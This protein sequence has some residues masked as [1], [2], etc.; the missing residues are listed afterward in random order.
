VSDFSWRVNHV[1]HLVRIKSVSLNFVVGGRWRGADSQQP[2]LRVRVP[3]VDARLRNG[4]TKHR[5]TSRASSQRSH[6]QEKGCRYISCTRK[7][8]FLNA[9]SR[10]GHNSKVSVTVR[11]SD[12]GRDQ[13]IRRNAE[14]WRRM[15]LHSCMTMAVHTVD[16]RQIKFRGV[17][18]SSGTFA[19]SSVRSAL[20]T[21]RYKW[22]LSESC[23]ARMPWEPNKNVYFSNGKQKLEGR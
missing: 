12:T 6:P 3:G 5:Q 13:A 23:E 20:R 4:N 8:Q 9:I 17:G 14:E 18:T 2:K 15:V 16:L 10:E 11:F 21:P 7:D 22:S 19:L 1:K